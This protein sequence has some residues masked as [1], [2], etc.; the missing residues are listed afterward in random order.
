M[1]SQVCSDKKKNWYMFLVKALFIKLKHYLLLSQLRHWTVNYCDICKNHHCLLADWI[2]WQQKEFP[3]K[4]KI[5]SGDR[6]AH[7]PVLCILLFGN[8]AW[9]WMNK[10]K[11]ITKGLYYKLLTE[12]IW[13]YYRDNALCS[14]QATLITIL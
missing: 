3:L 2:F 5:L 1:P 11:P 6:T 4:K 10:P 13:I 12:L 7:C 14:C 9:A 8:A